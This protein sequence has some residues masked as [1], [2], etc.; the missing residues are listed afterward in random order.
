M[1][2]RGFLLPDSDAP[3]ITRLRQ[4]T[5]LLVRGLMLER[6]DHAQLWRYAQLP[7]AE[8]DLEV[9]MS[10]LRLAP[11][12]APERASA[13]VRAEIIEASAS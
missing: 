6:A 3:G 13:A 4:R 1:H 5:S 2:Y 10:I 12:D 8:E 11:A 9:L 7:E